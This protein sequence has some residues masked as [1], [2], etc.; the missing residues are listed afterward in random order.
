MQTCQLAVF[1]SMAQIF[2]RWPGG[3]VVAHGLLW[4]RRNE[5]AMPGIAMVVDFYSQQF[6][7]Y[8]VT[9]VQPSVCAF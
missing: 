4:V 7:R 8:D 2:R 5:G 3:L 6:R 9:F 1:L